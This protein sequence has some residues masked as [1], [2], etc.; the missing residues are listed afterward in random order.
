[1]TYDLE[2]VQQLCSEIGLPTSRKDQHVEVDLG[3]GVL[4]CIQNADR[5]EDCLIG[6]SDSPWHFHDDLMFA[7][8][9]GSYIEMDYLN[10]LT[11]LADG[12]VLV[13]ER[14][15]G[16]RIA[17]RWLTHERYNNELRRMEEGERVVIRRATTTISV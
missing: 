6:F 4:L 2:V 11:G 13:C 12:H 9:G 17:D 1:M 10:I 16:D 7:D 5:E 8:G 14:Q 15:V 3:E